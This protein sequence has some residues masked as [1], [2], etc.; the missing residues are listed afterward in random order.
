VSEDD[1][2]KFGAE[3]SELLDLELTLRLTQR[4]VIF[5]LAALD[6]ALERDRDATTDG[7]RCFDKCDTE[8]VAELSS[9]L[10][11]AVFVPLK[12]GRII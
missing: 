9:R 8:R 1:L 4:E 7:E 11:A 10:D 5:V 2:R 12:G 6:H 3:T